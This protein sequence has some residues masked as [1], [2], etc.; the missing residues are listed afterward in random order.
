L[1]PN[2]FASFLEAFMQSFE[3]FVRTFDVPAFVPV[4][5]VCELAGF[6]K[7]K[8]Y[9]LNARNQLP[10][11]KLGGSAGVLAKDLYDFLNQLPAA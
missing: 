2:Y 5:R 10:V 1:Q 6:G 11:R 4:A 8:L 7:S 3:E 9:E